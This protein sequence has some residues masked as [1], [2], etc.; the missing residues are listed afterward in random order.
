MKELSGYWFGSTRLSNSSS[1]AVDASLPV[2]PV[3]SASGVV[4]RP[5]VFSPSASVS[6]SDSEASVLGAV[7]CE[8][9]SAQAW[10]PLPQAPTR[11]TLAISRANTI[12]NQVLHGEA[13]FSHRVLCTVITPP[14]V[15]QDG[16]DYLDQQRQQRDELQTAGPHL[17]DVHQLQRHRHAGG[18]D[19]GEAAV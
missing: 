2:T 18:Y 15:G 4:I 14:V 5:D 13:V 12:A 3:L 10:L 7:Y 16:D 1:S 9:S 6:E 11:A 19:G 8:G 17:K